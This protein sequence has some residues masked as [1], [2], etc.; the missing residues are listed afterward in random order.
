MIRW[1]VSDGRWTVSRRGVAAT[2]E[3]AWTDA[4]ACAA[5]IAAD[6]LDADVLFLVVGEHAARLYPADVG[7]SGRATTE[8]VAADLAD[9]M[10][11]VL[12][13]PT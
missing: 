13:P 8:R 3:Q 1:Q 10:R 5:M 12:M 6:P 11:G 9:A 4:A 2:R 7:Q